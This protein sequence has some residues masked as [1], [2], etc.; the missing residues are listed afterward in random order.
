VLG[1]G[2]R[3]ALKEFVSVFRSRRMLLGDADGKGEGKSLLR[4]LKERFLVLK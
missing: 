4:K 2:V 3:G 1:E